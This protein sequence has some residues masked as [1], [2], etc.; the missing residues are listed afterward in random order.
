MALTLGSTH[1]ARRDTVYLFTRMHSDQQLLNG[2]LELL[3]LALQLAALVGGDRAR[4]DLQYNGTKV[5]TS[6]HM[7]PDIQTLSK[8]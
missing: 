4:D 7:S 3:N 8:Y 6:F 1:T 5:S 2:K